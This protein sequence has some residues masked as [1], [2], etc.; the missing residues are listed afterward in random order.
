[1]RKLE[2]P[3]E[4]ARRMP[5]MRSK[6][7]Y[8]IRGFLRTGTVPGLGFQPIYVGRSMIATKPW[9]W[10]TISRSWWWI[11]FGMPM[12]VLAVLALL[13]VL[14]SSQSDVE[15]CFQA[16]E[17]LVQHSYRSWKQK[18]MNKR[19]TVCQMLEEWEKRRKKQVEEGL[20]ARFKVCLGGLWGVQCHPPHA[21]VTLS[22]SIQFSTIYFS[23][24]DCGVL[25]VFTSRLRLFNKSDVKQTYRHHADSRI[26]QGCA[27]QG[28]GRRLNAYASQTQLRNKHRLSEETEKAST[29]SIP[30]FQAIRT[31]NSRALSCFQR[32]IKVRRQLPRHWL[33]LPWG[34]TLT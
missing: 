6:A 17:G 26:I 14:A 31:Q 25:P 23:S 9:L 8:W 27:H 24:I 34:P 11:W 20:E 28:S 19:V 3:L 18:R 1:M 33:V 21:S 7:E 22:P 5:D 4:D 30:P 12:D 13:A 15:C 10:T 29:S 32:S 2:F 16:P